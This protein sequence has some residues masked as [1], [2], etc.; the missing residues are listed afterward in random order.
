MIFETDATFGNNPELLR[1]YENILND[2]LAGQTEQR[3]R[4]RI[5]PAGLKAVQLTGY[6]EKFSDVF[7]HYLVTSI[8]GHFG[9]LPSEIGFS[10]KGGMGSSGHQQGEAEAGHQLGLE[11]LQNWLAKIITNLSYS[12]LAMPRELEFKFMPSTRMDTEQQANRDD[13]E[14]RNG[15]MTLNEHRAENGQPLIDSPEADMPM[16]VA[17]Q[18][19]YLFT[20]EGV[21]AAGTSLDANGVQDNEPSA[22]E[23]PKPE[24]PD[25]PERTEVKKFMR[26]VNRGTPMRPFNFE[27]L[28]HAY[29]EVLNK[30]VEEKDLDGARWYAERYLGL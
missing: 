1:A 26:F 21:V 6:G 29:A 28:D 15:G 7:D 22:T 16:L 30:F 13:V 11:P 2:D 23:A 14:V 4:A 27:H 19:V 25:T 17:G 18:S 20:P 24:V 9:V 5:M 12:Y 8:C 3:K 10:Q